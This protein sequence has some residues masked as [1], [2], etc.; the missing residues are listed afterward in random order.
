MEKRDEW[1]ETA[2]SEREKDNTVMLDGFFI[3]SSLFRLDPRPFDRK[4]V[5]IVAQIFREIEIFSETII[6]IASEAG[7]IIFGVRRFS[8]K[9]LPMRIPAE[10]LFRFARQA[11]GI[12][13]LPFAP[14]VVLPS[15]NLMGSGRRAPI[16]FFRKFENLHIVSIKEFK[17]LGNTRQLDGCGFEFGLA[18][19]IRVPNQGFPLL[20]QVICPDSNAEPLSPAFPT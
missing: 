16:K 6:V 12:C 2:F 13:F 20:A 1:L 9:F 8:L 19:M 17:L 4:A 10:V 7:N 18:R 14:I 5:G 3:E 15:L 11:L